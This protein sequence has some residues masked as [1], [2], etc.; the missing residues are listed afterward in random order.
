MDTDPLFGPMGPWDA[1]RPNQVVETGNTGKTEKSAQRMGYSIFIPQEEELRTTPMA[2]TLAFQNT[3]EK[4]WRQVVIKVLA[5]KGWVPGCVYEDTLYPG[6]DKTNEIYSGKIIQDE[7]DHQQGTRKKDT[8][9]ADFWN[10]INQGMAIV[11]M[12]LCQEG[13]VIYSAN[14]LLGRTMEGYPWTQTAL[15]LKTGMENMYQ[16]LVG[17]KE[18]CGALGETGELVVYTDYEPLFDPIQRDRWRLYGAPNPPTPDQ[19]ALNEILSKWTRLSNVRAIVIRRTRATKLHRN[20]VERR[21]KKRT[22][23]AV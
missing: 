12:V 14:Y 8:I 18:R 3:G 1:S 21:R 15:A 5:S 16:L 17:S 20:Q 4:D 7:N 13:Q 22:G 6:G 23:G 11:Q 19:S 10:W 9:E 2:Q